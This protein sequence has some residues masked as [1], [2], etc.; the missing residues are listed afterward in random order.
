M[1]QSFIAEATTS[2]IAGSSL[3]PVSIVL[4]SALKTGFGN[5]FFMTDLLKTLQPK[6]SEVDVS[7]KL[8]GSESGL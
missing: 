7:M 2:A 5:R 4:Q 3:S 6:S 1:A 8:S